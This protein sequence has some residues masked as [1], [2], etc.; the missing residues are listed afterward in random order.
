MG[1]FSHMSTEFDNVSDVLPSKLQARFLYRL[2]A[3]HLS[4][5]SLLEL[6]VRV[7]HYQPRIVRVF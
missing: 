2:N 5:R 7:N 3:M 1:E 4:F 6:I